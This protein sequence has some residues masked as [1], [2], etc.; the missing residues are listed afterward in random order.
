VNGKS[1]IPSISSQKKDSV[2]SKTPKVNKNFSKA[3]SE[4][5]DRIGSTDDKNMLQLQ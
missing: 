1:R 3:P 2:M 5:Y 4:Y